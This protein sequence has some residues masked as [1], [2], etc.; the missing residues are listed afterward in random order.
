MIE[1]PK[2]DDSDPDDSLT[3][4]EMEI[5]SSED[6]Y[7]IRQYR[8]ASQDKLKELRLDRKN[9]DLKSLPTDVRNKLME[10]FGVRNLLK[11]NVPNQKQQENEG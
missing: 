10:E 11:T 4:F 8:L 6:I 2:N 5:L 3:S 1:R 7:S 9:R